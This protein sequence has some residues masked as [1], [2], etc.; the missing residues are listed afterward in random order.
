MI[1]SFL[2]FL[3]SIFCLFKNLFCFE[4]NEENKK[5]EDTLLAELKHS[6]SSNIKKPCRILMVDYNTEA[7]NIIK[8]IV[9]FKNMCPTVVLCKDEE[10]HNAYTRYVPEEYIFS[11]FNDDFVNSLKFKR[12]SKNSFRS[13]MVV[14]DNSE[15]YFENKRLRNIVDNYY[16][17]NRTV[18][19]V[20][21]DYM[22]LSEDFIKCFDFVFI[23]NDDEINLIVDTNSSEMGYMY[24]TKEVPKFKLDENKYV[25]N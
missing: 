12:T 6:L 8:E 21:N 14:I 16:K 11:E 24:C 1:V 15:E 9:H 13:H 4:Q 10:N 19:V 18:I 17:Y 7:K 23:N 25:Y 2:L 20:I 22:N 3:S 5:D